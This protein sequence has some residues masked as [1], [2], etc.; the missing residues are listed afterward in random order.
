MERNGYI[1][2]YRSLRSNFLYDVRPF[3]K[4]HAWI[5]LLFLAN[6][7]PA[8]I[9]FD[10]SLVKLSPGQ[11]IT[12]QRKLA[13]KWGWDR[14]TVNKFLAMLKTAEMITTKTDNKMT[15]IAINNWNQ[16]QQNPPQNTPERL[17]RIPT[18]NKVNKDNKYITNNSETSSPVENPSYKELVGSDSNA[19]KYEFQDTAL[20][21][22]QRLGVPQNK[23]SSVFKV[24][25]EENESH[26]EAAYR[27]AVDYP[28]PKLKTQMFFWK[29]N[30][31]KNHVN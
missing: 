22:I 16:Y 10:G 6:Y 5:D 31:V 3:D 28:Q 2:L 25:K 17:H 13:D 14:K 23:K 15:F 7:Q 9:M 12:S 8:K 30:E 19:P 1:L 18:E 21:I 29:L 11:F 20:E 4:T 24:C 27:F 26:V